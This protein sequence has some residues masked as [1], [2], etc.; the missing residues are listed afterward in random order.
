MRAKTIVCPKIRQIEIQEKEIPNKPGPN[1]IIVKTVCSLISA[2]TELSVYSGSHIGYSNPNSA[3]PKLPWS[4]GY[5]SAGVVYAIGDAVEGLQ[6]NDRVAVVVPHADFTLCDTQKTV[7]QIIPENVSFEEGAL[8]RLA[9]ISLLGVL[10]AKIAIGETV[11]VFGLGLIGHF[12]AQLSYIHGARPV[13]GIDLIE[14]RVELC[15]KFGIKS[16]L[17]RKDQEIDQIMKLTGGIR[18]EVILESTGNPIAIS[19]AMHLAADGGRVIELGSSQVKTE[20]DVYSTIHRNAII[21][22]GVHD[23]LAPLSPIFPH[24]RTR[25]RNLGL[26][27]SLFADGSLKSEGLITNRIKPKEIKDIYD[28]MLNNPEAFMGVLIEW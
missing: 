21:V 16:G 13:I 4:A 25:P 11:V 26:I 27:L 2:G 22:S 20:I 19:Q 14:N 17:L 7:I 24:L 1:E 10:H 15:K 8:A 6:T 23:R 9:G 28:A 12:A 18:P 5:A 3:F